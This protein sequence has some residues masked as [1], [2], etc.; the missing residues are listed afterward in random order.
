MVAY[1]RVVTGRP[2][3]SPSRAGDFRQCPLLYRFRAIDRLPE[4]PGLAQV[5]GTLVHAVLERL[6]DLPAA[7]RVPAAARALVA[8]AWA[9]LREDDPALAGALFPEAVPGSPEAGSEPAWLASAGALLDGYFRLEDPR[10]L[11]PEGRELLVETELASGLPLRG[12]LDRLDVG[13]GGALRIVDY[14]TGAAP[15]PVAEARA[16]FPMKFYA[17]A[18]LQLRGVVPAQLRLIYLADGQCLTYA[19][20]EEELRRFQRVL[21]ALWEAVLAAGATGDFRASPSRMCDWCSHRSLC[22]AWGGT[23]PP[24]PGWPTGADEEP[25]PDHAD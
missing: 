9:R 8:P 22:P 23:P 1:P 25:V 12:Y 24:Y 14:K 5:R 18:L 3:L 6:F 15:H 16:L 10:G 2:A 19:P 7:Q 17:L 21:E 4:R 11:E 20:D 13:P